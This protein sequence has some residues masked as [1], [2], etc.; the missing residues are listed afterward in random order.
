M[1]LIIVKEKGFQA[2]LC[3]LKR[4]DYA[5]V[6]RHAYS[7]GNTDVIVGARTFRVTM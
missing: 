6:M 2:I 4:V 1:T 3:L 5:I 7:M